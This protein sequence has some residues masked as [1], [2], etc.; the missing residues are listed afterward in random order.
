MEGLSA[1]IRAIYVTSAVWVISK[2]RGHVWG[3]FPFALPVIFKCGKME[4]VF[5]R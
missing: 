5:L 4:F 2:P 3:A 1:E